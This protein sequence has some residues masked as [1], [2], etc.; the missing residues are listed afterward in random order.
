MVLKETDLKILNVAILRRMCKTAKIPYSGL[1]KPKMFDLFNK[2]LSVKIIQ[3][4]YRNHFYRDAEDPITM[5]KVNYPCFIFRTK[6]KLF[7][8]SYDTIIKNI[9]KTGNCRD[10]MTRIIYSDEDLNR[11]DTDVK[12]HFPNNVYKSTLKIKNNPNY[13][14][15]ISNRENEIMTFDMRLND[16]K[17]SILFII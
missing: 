14:K 16:L 1:T 12:R 2:H 9:M 7:F 15:R 5:E 4:S 13:A 8:Y 17:T 6:L 11:L 3:N 10:P